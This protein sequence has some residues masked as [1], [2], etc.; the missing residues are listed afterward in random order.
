MYKIFVSTRIFGHVT[1]MVQNKPKRSVAFLAIPN[2]PKYYRWH[3]PAPT[4]Q[5]LDIPSTTMRHINV[6]KC[7]PRCVPSSSSFLPFDV[8]NENSR[9]ADYRS[10]YPLTPPLPSRLYS[11]SCTLFTCFRPTFPTSL[12][13]I[14]A[15]RV[16]KLC[17]P[18]AA[19]KKDKLDVIRFVD[20][21]HVYTLL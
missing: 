9:H 3:I 19:W 14:G 11:L 15:E 7:R 20:C 21:V 18:I 1:Q 8:P 16:S 17:L 4:Y 6:S 10:L 12:L 5:V 13:Y 2:E